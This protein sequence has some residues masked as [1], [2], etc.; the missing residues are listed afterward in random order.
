M[1]DAI[2]WQIYGNRRVFSEFLSTLYML[3]ITNINEH[4]SVKYRMM[5]ENS[6][7]RMV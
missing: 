7:L 1:I 5:N 3:D 4:I 6:F 2:E